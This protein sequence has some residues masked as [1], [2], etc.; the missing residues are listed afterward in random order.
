MGPLTLWDADA[1]STEWVAWEASVTPAL[2]DGLIHDGTSPTNASQLE[3][4]RSL[5]LPNRRAPS[6]SVNDLLGCSETLTVTT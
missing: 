1:P 6:S 2:L 5:A 3:P 4:D